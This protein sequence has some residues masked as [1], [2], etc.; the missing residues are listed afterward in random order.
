[1]SGFNG[2][3]WSVGQK[4][5]IRDKESNRCGHGIVVE[6][7]PDCKP[8]SSTRVNVTRSVCGGEIVAGNVVKIKNLYLARFLEG[9]RKSRKM[10]KA[11]K[12][13]KTRKMKKSKYSR[14]R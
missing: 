13:K 10:K 4:V 12:M 1:M 5:E 8:E 11:R 14:R 9:G 3:Y 2:N 7:V 6:L